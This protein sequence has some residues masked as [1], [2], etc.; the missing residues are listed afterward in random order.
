MNNQ[1][2]Q[3]APA[4]PQG[5]AKPSG[6]QVMLR[7]FVNHCS[8]D[9]F[10][11]KFSMP[12][13]AGKDREGN[14]RKEYINVQVSNETLQQ[15]NFSEGSKVWVKG[16]I[17]SQKFQDK[18]TGANRYATFIQAFN[19]KEIA[20]PNPQYQQRPPQQ[21]QYQQQPYQQPASPPPPQQQQYQQPVAPQPNQNY[22]QASQSIDNQLQAAI[23]MDQIPF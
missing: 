17:R 21:Q 9:N 14:F 22:Q 5:Q 19:I 15:T 12:L 20:P 11:M 16:R 1:F 23:D 4:Q 3:Q 8:Q 18:Q 13:E 10:G 6:N 2:Q 7:G